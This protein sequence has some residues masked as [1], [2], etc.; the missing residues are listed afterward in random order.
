MFDKLD[1]I[2]AAILAGGQGTRLRTVVS[3]RQK[4][5][6]MVAGRPFLYRLLDQ[7][8]DAGVRKVVLCTGFQAVNVAATLGR[9]Y[10]NMQFFYSEESEPLGT[11]GALRQALPLCDSNPI[12]GL[13]GDSYCEID[14]SAMLAAHRNPATL[15][16]REVADTTRSGRVEFDANDFVT[17][18]V[19]KSTTPGR[20]WLSA[21]IYLLGREVLES[22]PAGRPVS[23]ERETFPSLVGRGLRAFCTAGRFLDIGT[24][25]AYTKAQRFFK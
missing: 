1:G 4:V 21:G 3:D 7:L 11:A 6:A 9:A 2:T 13:N 14:F 10:R 22:I 16:V 12:L 20:G 19:E 25:S 5:V 23:I 18:F 15:A 8:A 24:P 17:S